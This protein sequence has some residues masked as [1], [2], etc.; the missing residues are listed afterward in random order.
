MVVAYFMHHGIDALS[1]LVVNWFTV[2]FLIVSVTALLAV[3][4]S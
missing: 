2:N 1:L 3:L 4:V